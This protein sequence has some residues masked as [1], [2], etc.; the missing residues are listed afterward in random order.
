MKFKEER[1]LANVDVAVKKL[2]EIANGLEA[3]HAG[4]IQINAINNQFKEAGGSYSEYVAAVKASVDLGYL[5][6]HPSG[7]YVTFTQAGADLFA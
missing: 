4:R 3:D 5:T 1:P 6:M 7:G 2:L